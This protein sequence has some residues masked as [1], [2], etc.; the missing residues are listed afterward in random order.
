[1]ETIPKDILVDVFVI[2]GPHGWRNVAPVC[3]RWAKI[4]GDYIANAARLHLQGKQSPIAEYN[5]P[6]ARHNIISWPQLIFLIDAEDQRCACESADIASLL[7]NRMIGGAKE[8]LI[9]TLPDGD[10]EELGL[11]GLKDGLVLSILLYASVKRPALIADL[12]EVIIEQTPNELL[13]PTS[14]R[15]RKGTSAQKIFTRLI[16][17]A[18]Q[19]DTMIRGDDDY[20]LHAMISTLR[21]RYFT[22]RPPMLESELDKT[23]CLDSREAFIAIV[24]LIKPINEIELFVPDVIRHVQAIRRPCIRDFVVREWRVEEIIGNDDY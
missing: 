9:A 2:I 19:Y 7:R 5:G 17:I 1:M 11:S 18:S 21:I 24:A 15:S 14:D 20:S 16:R 6:L 22:N 23:T 8:A 4:I 12:I 10:L 13:I 3:R